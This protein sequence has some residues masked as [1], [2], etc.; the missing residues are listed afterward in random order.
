MTEKEPIKDGVVETFHK[1]GQLLEERR[2]YKDW[3]LEGLWERF[4]ENGEL[5]SRG[6]YKNGK[7]GG[8]REWFQ[9]NGQLKGKGNF[10][11]WKSFSKKILNFQS[12]ISQE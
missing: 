10:K 5:R 4:Y 8:L 12:K 7:K 1:N 2:N 3:E 6:N 9:E 11:N